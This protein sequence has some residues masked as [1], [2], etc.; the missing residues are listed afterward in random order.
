M[1]DRFFT[2]N[3]ILA[4]IIPFIIVIIT[5]L[6]FSFIY[7]L[8]KKDK[9]YKKDFIITLSLLPII[10]VCLV[11]ITNIIIDEI[12]ASDTQTERALTALI[13][14]ILLIR[15]RSKNLETEDLT[16]IFFMFVYS[17]IIGLGY[18]FVGLIIFLI[19]L[20]LMIILNV[21][22]ILKFDDIYILKVLI[23]E[24][25]AFEEELKEIFLKNTKSYNLIS[26]K[27]R[28]MGISLLLTY[29]IRLDKNNIKKLIDDIKVK[30]GNMTINLN[31]RLEVDYE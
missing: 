12:I 1:I 18:I 27:S 14:G 21:I 6:V 5:S 10:S 30:N 25:M 31:K 3:K 4:F 23:P 22:K 13:A 17:F 15:F 8:V 19:V 9:I 26:V 7:M 28:D 2:D 20:L 24:D 16:Y 11:S 29:Q